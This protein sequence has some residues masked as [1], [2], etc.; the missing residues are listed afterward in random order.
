MYTNK[1]TDQITFKGGQCATADYGL[2]ENGNISVRNYETIGDKYDGSTGTDVI[3]GYAYVVDPA[4]PG[5]LRVSLEGVPGEAP[6]WVAALGPVN[7]ANLYDYA[8]VSDNTGSFLFVLARNSDEFNTKYD[9]EVQTLMKDL[10]FTGAFTAPFP[11]HQGADCLY[12]PTK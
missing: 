1:L 8:L 4:E 5:K 10:G 7:T 11:I 3:T 6:Y 2:L 12:E 9:A